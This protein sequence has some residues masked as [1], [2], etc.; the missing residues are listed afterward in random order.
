[1]FISFIYSTFAK[2]TKGLCF[3][4]RFIINDLCKWKTSVRR[5]PLILNGA[6]QVGKTWIL[7]QFAKLE[8]DNIAY[9][10]CDE[11]PLAARLFEDYDINRILRALEA[12]THTQISAGKTLI[13]IDEIQETPRGLH[14]LKYFAENAPEQHVV[15][16]G[17]L[18]GILLHKGENFPVGKVN[19]LQMHPMSFTEFLVAIGE[20]QLSECISSCD[21]Q[22]INMLHDKTIRLLKLY[23]YVGGM[24]EAVQ[25][26]CDNVPLRDIRTIHNEILTT[27]RND[28]SKHAPKEQVIRITQVL[29]SIPAQVAKENKKFI[30]GMIKKGARAKDFEIAIQWLQDAGIILKI[31]NVSKPH[32]PLH[33]YEDFDSFKLFLLDCGLLGAMNQTDA[34]EITLTDNAFDEYNGALAEQLVL[35]ELSFLPDIPI[36]YYTKPNAR[37]EIDFLTEIKNQVLPIEVKSGENLQ[38]KSL[39]QFIIENAPIRAVKSSLLPFRHNEV[40]DNVPLYALQS[41]INSFQQ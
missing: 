36:Y 17:S 27:Y 40:I 23:L 14:A 4:E 2:R 41:Y 28:L 31:C 13:F 21:W 12:L 26:Y 18:L 30:F 10:N 32:A 39:K 25:A 38:S 11:E 37:Q 8:Y 35:Q 6:R 1:M 9:L 19:I 3:M 22:L 16:A 34:S 20:K 15:V 33:F 24:P 7:K 29:D 5:K